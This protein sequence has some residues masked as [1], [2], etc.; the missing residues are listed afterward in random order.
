MKLMK[1][2]FGPVG[3]C[4]LVFYMDVFFQ[5]FMSLSKVPRSLKELLTRGKFW[6]LYKAARS[7]NRPAS[8]L[9]SVIISKTQ[10][11]V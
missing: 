8:T 5:R 9:R 10:N 2:L 7:T 6:S 3:L 4:V 1:F 11:L